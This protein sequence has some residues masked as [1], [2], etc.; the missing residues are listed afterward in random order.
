[1]FGALHMCLNAWRLS[2][3]VLVSIPKIN[4]PKQAKVGQ[5]FW[6]IVK[7]MCGA[8]GSKGGAWHHAKPSMRAKIAATR[9]LTSNT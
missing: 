2:P 1:M 7:C 8:Q 9:A 3:V 6:G 4:G 5:C